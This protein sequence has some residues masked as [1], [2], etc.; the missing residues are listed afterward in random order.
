MRNVT[1]FD[2]TIAAISTPSGS[3]GIG[4]VR[5][6]GSGSLA[7]ADKIFSS[8]KGPASEFATYTLHYGHVID[9]RDPGSE[10]IVDEALLAVMRAPRSYTRED[11]VEISCH[12]GPVAVREVLTLAMHAGA[13]LADPGEFTRRA[14]LNGRIDLTQAEAVMDIIRAKTS[15]GLRVSE[16]QLNGKLAQ[17]LDAVRER[18]MQVYSRVEAALN[19]PENGGEEGAELTGGLD[20]IERDI[21]RLLQQSEQG[22]LI[23]EGVRV[24]LCGRPNVGKSSL[25]NAILRDARAIVSEVAGT[26]RDVIEEYANIQGVPVQLS[27]TAGILTP[28]DAIEEEAVRRSR[29]SV[30]GADLVIL[31]VDAAQPWSQE[32]AGIAGHLKEQNVLVALNKIDQ[33]QRI[34]REHIEM[35]FPKKDIVPVSALTGGGLK[36]LE[37]M[38]LEKVLHEPHRAAEEMYLTNARHIEALRETADELTC[39]KNEKNEALPG[40]FISERLTRAIS[41]LDRITGRDIDQ[42]LLDKIFADFCIGK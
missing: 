36:D 34:S 11:V 33:V 21:R 7:V 19:F 24:V 15:A 5:I 6:S 18:I 12:G 9:R 28:R 35:F 41:C 25:L 3:G 8:S 14:F 39:L 32:D 29:A 20:E 4:I 10:R 27:D 1:R 38:I 13:R 22:R 17:R 23:R 37:A 26:T 31:V 40:E 16:N 30:S 42:D 2:D